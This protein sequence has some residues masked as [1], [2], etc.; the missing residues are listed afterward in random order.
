MLTE[1][2]AQPLRED[3]LQNAIPA[4]TERRLSEMAEYANPVLINAF[5][6]VNIILQGL[7]KVNNFFINTIILKISKKSLSFH[8]ARC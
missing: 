8:M 3:N 2:S 7:T 1:F 4:Y 5:D 6:I